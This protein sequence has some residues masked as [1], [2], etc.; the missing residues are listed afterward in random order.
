[1]LP[2]GRIR[3]GPKRAGRDHELIP[4]IER[5]FVENSAAYSARKVWRQLC[6]EASI[7]PGEVLKGT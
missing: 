3:L 7:R 2:G 5:L 6:R 4:E 1:M